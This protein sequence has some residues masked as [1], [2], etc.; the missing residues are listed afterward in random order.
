MFWSG[1]KKR[2][3][4]PILAAACDSTSAYPVLACQHLTAYTLAALVLNLLCLLSGAAVCVGE[5]VKPLG[6]GESWAG[7]WSVVMG[8]FK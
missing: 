6:A 2:P 4:Q 3:N 5:L 1:Q 8:S 7:P